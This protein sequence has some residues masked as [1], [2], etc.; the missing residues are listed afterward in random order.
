[1][2]FLGVMTEALPF[3]PRSFE[4]PLRRDRVPSRRKL[5]GDQLNTEDC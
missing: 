5:N 3:S 2:G 1:M 4:V